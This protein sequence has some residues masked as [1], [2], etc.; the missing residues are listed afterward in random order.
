MEHHVTWTD[1]LCV[2]KPTD[3]PVPIISFG[4]RKSNL[5]SDL[6]TTPLNK[7]IYRCDIIV[8][9][10]NN[11]FLSGCRRKMICLT[12]CATQTNEIVIF[13]L[14]NL[15]AFPLV[16]WLCYFCVCTLCIDLVLRTNV[17]SP[18]VH[19]RKYFQGIQHKKVQK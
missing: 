14:A 3:P 6:P 1:R 15:H 2:R 13:V 4:L 12:L 8:D 7:S 17:K 10:K 9:T 11:L 16:L 18:F 5:C 19:S